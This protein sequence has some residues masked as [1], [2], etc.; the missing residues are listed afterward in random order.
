M[1]RVTDALR[2]AAEQQANADQAVVDEK[3]DLRADELIAQLAREPFPIELTEHRRARPTPAAPAAVAPST[4][5]PAVPSPPAAAPLMAPAGAAL[6]TTA[7]APVMPAAAPVS[8]PLKTPSAEPP[9]GPAPVALLERIS[10]TLRAKIVVDDAIAPTSREQYRKLAAALHHQQASSGIK[11]VMIA[12]AVSGEGK[13]LTASNLA[14]T[15][16]ESYQRNVLLID[17]DLRRPYV[18]VVF[19][20]EQSPG[21]SEGLAPLDDRRVRSVQV[22]P[23]LAV[24]PAG[25]ATTDPMAGLTSQRM[26]RLLAEA[27]ETF[28]W[29]II[30][31]PPVTLL[32]DANLL[33]GMVD[34]AVL[35]VKAGST[36]F[37]LVNRAIDAIGRSK[38][39]GIVLNQVTAPI[40]D[41]NYYQSYYMDPPVSQ[42]KRSKR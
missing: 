1:N 37:N 29:V 32:P 30:D 17:A 13:T 26:Q 14:L 27:R 34:V 24:L 19:G 8:A 11:I 38:T 39:V 18:H 40:A 15:L 36:P 25:A 33:A 41:A 7:V 28:D 12:S 16:S 22:S 23:R 31:T 5:S 4:P 6:M 21:L 9:A 35:I 20:V 10:T 3:V 42:R 2:R